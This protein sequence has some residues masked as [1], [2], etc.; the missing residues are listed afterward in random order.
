[1]VAAAQ[2]IQLECQNVTRPL[3]GRGRT[4]STRSPAAA[5]YAEMTLGVIILPVG[6]LM[7]WG[8]TSRGSSVDVRMRRRLINSMNGGMFSRGNG[9]K[10]AAHWQEYP[11]LA[12]RTGQT[13][14]VC[15][16]P[17]LSADWIGVA[18]TRTWTRLDASGGCGP[19]IRDIEPQR[20]CS[21]HSDISKLV[22]NFEPS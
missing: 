12:T 5:I 9:Q 3:C 6:S 20:Y 11:G 22:K 18:I 1:M 16:P 10:T 15:F 14:M 19:R 4:A 21:C 13:P 8:L 7:F 2:P 17:W